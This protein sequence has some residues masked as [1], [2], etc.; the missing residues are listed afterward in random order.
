[1]SSSVCTLYSTKYSTKL[2]SFPSTT[3]DCCRFVELNSLEHEKGQ[4]FFSTDRGLFLS[5]LLENLGPRLAAVFQPHIERLV[6]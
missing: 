2:S 3:I 5:F 4:D 6:G 1:M